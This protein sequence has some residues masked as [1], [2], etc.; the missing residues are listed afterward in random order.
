M[1][2]SKITRIL[3]LVSFLTLII[4]GSDAS[5]QAVNPSPA[6]QPPV[7]SAPTPQHG[8]GHMAIAKQNPSCQNILNAC[9]Q[10]GF[11]EGQSKQGSGLWKDC[12]HPIVSSKGTPTKNGQAVTVPVNASDVQTCHSAMEAAH[13]QK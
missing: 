10:A 1:K 3:A 5:A 7:G 6:G 2:I 12:F 13:K 8:G 9:K 11:A 4:S